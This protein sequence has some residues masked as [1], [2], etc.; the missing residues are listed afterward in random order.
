MPERTTSAPAVT[1]S[2]V[3]KTFRI[4]KE[5]VHTLKE[6]VLHP[7]RRSADNEFSALK[8]VSFDVTKGGFFGIVG[9]NGSGKSTLLKCLAGIY[10]TDSGSIHIDGQVSTFIEL[11][12]GFNP[13]LAARD[14]VAINAA[15]LGLSK[16]EALRRFDAVIDFAEL[17]EFTALKLKNYSSGMMVRLAFAV[18][19]EIDADVLLIDEV[20]AVGDASFQQKC[21]DEFEKIRASGR[22]VLLV[23]HDMGAVQRFCDGGIL[24]EHGQVVAAGDPQAVSDRYL[25]LNFSETA[26]ERAAA[27]AAGGL[28]SPASA[29]LGDG[30][31]VIE[32]VWFEL[33]RG[34]EATT[35]PNGERATFKMQI[36]FSEPVNEPVFSVMLQ[37]G[38]GVPLLTASSGWGWGPTG[39]FKAGETVQWEAAF[40]N[41][42]GPGRYTVTPS[43][44]L[45]GGAV[46]ALRE[47]LTTVVVTRA[48]PT[49]TLIDIPTDQQ[50]SRSLP[51]DVRQDLIR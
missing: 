3:S 41:I 10:T 48:R 4:P 30:R 21:F 39:S 38:N 24:L 16:R 44:T 27:A 14:N 25:D 26:R 7:L 32:R 6:R 1:V 11:G 28:D 13:D 42:L 5:Q 23:T 50:L 20:L 46:L 34:R 17:R 15:M 51:P 29:P 33:A 9:R 40:D 22:T 49:G 18:M 2:D 43:V 37:N 31:A 12:V 19:I 8:D 47:H 36:R 35:V 45:S